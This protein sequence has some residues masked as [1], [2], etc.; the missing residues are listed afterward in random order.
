MVYRNKLTGAEF[1]TDCEINA[2]NY[3]AI[4]SGV[5]SPVVEPPKAEKKAPAKKK[6]TKK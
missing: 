2:E 1:T 5:A 4:P 6:G 3:E